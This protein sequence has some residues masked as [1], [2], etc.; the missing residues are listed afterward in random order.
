MDALAVGGVLSRAGEEIDD[1]AGG[2]VGLA[3]G[4]EEFSERFAGGV[5]ELGGGGDFGKRLHHLLPG[6]VEVCGGDLS[7]AGQDRPETY[8]GLEG[9]ES[10]AAQGFVGDFVDGFGY[11]D[12]AG[13]GFAGE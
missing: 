5:K 3:A 12:E 11:V 6:V 8:V 7:L 1:G 4:C 2:S 13:C 10:V 9:S